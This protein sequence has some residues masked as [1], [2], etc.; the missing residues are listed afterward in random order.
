MPGGIPTVPGRGWEAAHSPC[1]IPT[2]G[3]ARV[4]QPPDSPGTVLRRLGTRGEPGVLPA[5]PALLSLP[6]LRALP[7]LPSLPALR[8]LPSL[9][10]ASSVLPGSLRPAAPLT[11]SAPL[12]VP[13]SEQP[14]GAQ[15]LWGTGG[16]CPFPAPQEGNRRRK[17]KKSQSMGWGG[18][19]RCPAPR[20]NTLPHPSGTPDP[21]PP[22]GA[23]P[24]FWVVGRSDAP[25][26]PPHRHH[27]SPGREKRLISSSA[28]KGS[29]TRSP[30]LPARGISPLGFSAGG[31]EQPPPWGPLPLSASAL[32]HPNPTRPH[33]TQP[34]RAAWAV[35]RAPRA[36]HRAPQTVR[37][38]P[39]IAHRPAHPAPRCPPRAPHPAR[40][41]QGAE[42]AAP[43]S[44]PALAGQA[45]CPSRTDGPAQTD[46]GCAVGGQQP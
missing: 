5:M 6:S 14:H 19:T 41:R 9:H 4:L 1:S 11:R 24:G 30:S 25:R 31:A 17:R 45:V 15:T 46:P 2:L 3:H 20:L 34:K 8:A 13:G 36:P 7:A 33:Q 26:P 37:H 42:P 35:R 23:R 22:S 16:A 38:G 43:T 39:G 44:L 10:K 28:E 40:C 21:S 32:Q 27:P 18:S 12:E 29:K